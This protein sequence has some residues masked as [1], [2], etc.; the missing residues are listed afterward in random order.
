RAPAPAATSAGNPARRGRR[1]SPRPPPGIASAAGSEESLYRPAGGARRPAR[2]R[3]GE[4]RTGRAR[5]RAGRRRDGGL[6]T[7]D[8]RW[9]RGEAATWW[10]EGGGLGTRR[11]ACTRSGGDLGAGREE[12]GDGVAEVGD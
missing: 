5:A 12:A 3:G 11:R 9:E 6:G 10:T 4:A 2:G 7:E 1:A 8:A